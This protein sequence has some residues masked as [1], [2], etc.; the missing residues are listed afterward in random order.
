LQNWKIRGAEQNHSQA[1]HGQ[2]ADARRSAAYSLLMP[3]QSKRSGAINMADFLKQ[4]CEN[5]SRLN[6][7]QL[8]FNGTA[9]AAPSASWIGWN[10]NI[11]LID[12]RRLAP[13]YSNGNNLVNPTWK[14]IPTAAIERIE[15][16]SLRT[17]SAILRGGAGRRCHLT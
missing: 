9:V 3:G 17:A 5:G 1:E 7:H 2:R 12:G 11:D 16:F 14:P 13:I 6:R 10:R 15:V 8:H 4:G